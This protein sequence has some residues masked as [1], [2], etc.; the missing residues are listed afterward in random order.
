M[1]EPPYSLALEE[2]IEQAEGRVHVGLAGR[3]GDGCAG[4]SPTEAGKQGHDHRK[5]DGQGH[6]VPAQVLHECLA[7]VVQE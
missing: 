4:L 7:G 6:H 3:R 1:P 5:D 2:G